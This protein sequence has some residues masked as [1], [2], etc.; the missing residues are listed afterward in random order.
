MLN[1]IRFDHDNKSTMLDAV[2]TAIYNDLN[3]I[4]VTQHNNSQLVL[5]EN[6]F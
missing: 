4:S 3:V 6:L 1:T 5:N 2:L